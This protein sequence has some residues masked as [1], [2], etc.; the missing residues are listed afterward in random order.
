MESLLLQFSLEDLLKALSYVFGIAAQTS[1]R[2]ASTQSAI[3]FIA[4]KSWSNPF[5]SS[6]IDFIEVASHEKQQVETTSGTEMYRGSH[7]NDPVSLSSSD[8][9]STRKALLLQMQRIA[10]QQGSP[11][12][13][14]SLGSLGSVPHPLPIVNRNNKTSGNQFSSPFN[15]DRM[16]LEQ[17]VRS[18]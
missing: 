5:V 9:D 17:E 3:S 2:S 13:S 4:K 1:F 12:D 6:A 11:D 15:V 7:L 10:N 8:E 14:S 18:H 16:A